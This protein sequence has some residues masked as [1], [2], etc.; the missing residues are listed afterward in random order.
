MIPAP[1]LD[2]YACK[3]AHQ[4][5]F[6]TSFFVTPLDKMQI[7]KRLY[8]STACCRILC[9]YFLRFLYCASLNAILP[10]P[11]RILFLALSSLSLFSLISFSFPCQLVIAIILLLKKEFCLFKWIF[12]YFLKEKLDKRPNN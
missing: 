11:L 10:F 7:L 3:E 1:V 9:R 12:I 4:F 5:L 2:P 8:F 6:Q